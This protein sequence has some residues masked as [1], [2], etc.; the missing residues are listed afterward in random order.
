MK[1][2]NCGMELDP[3]SKTCNAC[4]LSVEDTS[5]IKITYEDQEEEYVEPPV[6][7]EA[8]TF[9]DEESFA[10]KINELEKTSFKRED[11][12]YSKVFKILFGVF[13]IIII[14]FVFTFLVLPNISKDKV[15]DVLEDNTFTSEDWKSGEFML[16][17][18]F[19]RVDD[20]FSKYFQKIS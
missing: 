1:C 13:V 12:K 17:D 16:D 10:K 8:H 4:G 20:N 19:Y 7:V 5:Q 9:I 6:I 14:G 18:E 15:T 3:N 2:R 11:D